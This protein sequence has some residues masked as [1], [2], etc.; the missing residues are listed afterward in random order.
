VPGN[1]TLDQ[2]KAPVATGE[3]E[4]VITAMVD[5]QGCLMGKRF[6]AQHFL[7]AGIEETRGCN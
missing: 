6:H 4:T 5:M 3:I 7:A 2:L 1:L